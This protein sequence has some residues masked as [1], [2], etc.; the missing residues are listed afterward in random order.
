MFSKKQCD[1]A[2]QVTLRYDI[3]DEY[4]NEEFDNLSPEEKEKAT[5]EVWEL[6]ERKSNLSILSLQKIG[7]K[8]WISEPVLY[9]LFKVHQAKLRKEGKID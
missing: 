7:A 8:Y 2:R 9:C 5:E 6:F 4:I 1:E 3:E